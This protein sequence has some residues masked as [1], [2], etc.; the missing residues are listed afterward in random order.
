[1]SLPVQG[2]CSCLERGCDLEVRG[3]E[4]DSGTW[5]APSSASALCLSRFHEESGGCCQ[6][7]RKGPVERGI[8]ETQKN[9][10]EKCT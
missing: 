10:E 2:P 6:Q 3:Q 7:E 4:G 8:Q 5:G 1:M 9:E